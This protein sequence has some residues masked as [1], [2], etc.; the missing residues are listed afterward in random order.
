VAPGIKLLGSVLAVFI[1]VPTI[2][3]FLLI[4]SSLQA[5]AVGH[6]ARGLFGWL[7]VLPW[8]NP[9]FSAIAMAA[10]CALGGGTI[11]NVLIQERL[12]PLVSDTFAVPG[13]FHFFTAGTVTL[14]FLGALL[15]MIPA[16]WDGGVPWPKLA[17]RLPYLQTLGVYLFG[18]AGVWAGYLGAPR[19]ALEFSYEGLA[20][21]SW[22][23][24]M[25]VVG[26]G[27]LIMVATLLSYVLLL[28][29]AVLGRARLGLRLEELPA[30]AFRPEQGRGQPAWFAPVAVGLILVAIYVATTGALSLMQRLPL[31]GG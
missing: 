27:G 17:A 30:A 13:Y 5:C 22:Q 14:T 16:L 25:T 8:G 19:R 23:A 11:A 15:Y 6:G 24:L 2:A 28:G 29:A 31:G 26:L 9:S 7:R 20:P 3:V 1:S 21:S 4:V 18:I 12:A 10:L